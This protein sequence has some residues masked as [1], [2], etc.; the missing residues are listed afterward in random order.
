MQ[1][2]TR[3]KQTILLLFVL[4]SGTDLMA[5]EFYQNSLSICGNWMCGEMT[6]DAERGILCR[7]EFS[8]ENLCTQC[9][10]DGS[11]DEL[12]KGVFDGV[13]VHYR[14]SAGNFSEFIAINTDGAA[15]HFDLNFDAAKN[16]YVFVH[17]GLPFAYF[18]FNPNTGLYE[19]DPAQIC[20]DCFPKTGLCGDGTLDMGETL[21]TGE[22]CDDGN[23]V[24][25][26]GCDESC[27][28]EPGLYCPDFSTPD[29]V[30]DP[31][32]RTDCPDFSAQDTMGDPCNH[33]E[34]ADGYLAE[35]D[36]DGDGKIGLADSETVTAEGPNPLRCFELTSGGYTLCETASQND[37]CD[38]DITVPAVGF[39]QDGIFEEGA[40]IP[41]EPEDTAARCN[42]G[43]DN[44]GD[45]LIDAADNQCF[46][47]G[48]VSLHAWRAAQG[49]FLRPVQ[50]GRFEES[51][52][53]HRDNN[54][55]GWYDCFD[56]DCFYAQECPS[57][58]QDECIDRNGNGVIEGDWEDL[59]L[60][61]AGEKRLQAVC[62]QLYD[63][64]N[65][66][67]P[68][69]EGRAFLVWM[70]RYSG[71]II[72]LH[73]RQMREGYKRNSTEHMSFQYYFNLR[74]NLP[75]WPAGTNVPAA[76]LS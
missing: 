26:D 14:F 47:N 52:T 11:G 59:V 49:G 18:P 53:D 33:D 72:N 41:L 16:T 10:D 17:N 73:A 2:T 44:N 45:G 39:I 69:T 32:I 76:A 48:F 60:A 4:L 58:T 36:T 30:G 24:G 67:A 54:G 9:A 66:A 28:M 5:Q 71:R 57:V 31:C 1:Q 61:P 29:T 3:M 62:A 64:D 8:G 56:A 13:L 38:S 50:F 43:L 51:C 46:I 70:R 37:P 75:Y 12:C 74:R 65:S 6:L 42:D 63:A 35:V 25:G 19:I 55:D 23:N 27:I 34:D 7:R 68:D 20:W 15:Y 21:D 40:C 22:Q